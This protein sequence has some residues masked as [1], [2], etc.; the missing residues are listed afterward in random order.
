MWSVKDNDFLDVEDSMIH[1]V[2]DTVVFSMYG[3]K[4]DLTGVIT[5]AEVHQAS[6]IAPKKMA[7]VIDDSWI[8]L[9]N[10]DIL[11]NVSSHERYLNELMKL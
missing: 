6:S 8:I 11:I 9:L 10:K 5:S 2:G 1:L 4:N 3:Y 7:Y